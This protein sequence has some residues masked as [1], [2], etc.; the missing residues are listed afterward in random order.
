MESVPSRAKINGPTVAFSVALLFTA[1][2]LIWL[3]WTTLGTN[4]F[5]GEIENRHMRLQE[6]RGSIIHLDEVL[7]MSARMAATT[8]EP[9][10]EARYRAHESI[11]TDAINEALSLTPNSEAES[12]VKKTDAANLALIEMENKAFELVRQNRL[13]DAK[14]ILFSADYAGQKATYAAGMEN[15]YDELDAYIESAIE[16]KQA[17]GVAY[18]WIIVAALPIIAICWFIAVRAMMRWQIQLARSNA[19]LEKQSKE[20]ESINSS[21]DR[22]VAERTA[23][24]DNARQEALRLKDVAEGSNRAK[25]EFLA[26]MSHEIRTPMNGIIGMTELALGTDLTGEQREYLE[27]VKISGDSL[28]GVI[29]DILDFSKIEARRLDLDLIE[30][31]LH[32]ALEETVRLLAPRAHQKGLE[33]AY[34]LSPGVPPVIISDP[35]RIRQVIVNLVGNSVKFTESGE[36]VVRIEKEFQE[37]KRAT[38]RFSVMDTGIGVP[39]DKQ[40]KIFEAFTQADS[41]TTRRFGGTGLGLAIASQLVGLMGGRI[42]VESQAGEGSKFHFTLPVEVASHVSRRAVPK[43]LSDLKDMPVLVVDDNATNRRIMEEILVQWGM[44]PLVVDGGKTALEAMD[45]ATA[46]GKPYSLILIDYQMP[47]MDGFEL[48]NR[49]KSNPALAAS[50]IMMLSSVGQRGDAI[51]CRELGVAS[52]LTKPIRQSVLLDALLVLLANPSVPAEPAP[53]VTKHSLREASKSL[54]VL[55]AEDNPVNQML[56]VKMLQKRG[57]TIEVAPDGRAAVEAW[58]RGEFDAILMDVQMPIMD[59]LEATGEIRRREKEKGTH[60]PIIAMTAHAMRGDRERCLDAGMDAY[61]PKPIHANDLFET[62]E[63]LMPTATTAVR[64]PKVRTR[65]SS[66]DAVDFSA[67]LGRVDG[68]RELLSEVVELFRADAPRL[69]ENVKSAIE[70]KDAKALAFAA[71]ALKGALSAISAHRASQAALVLEVMGRENDWTSSPTAALAKLESELS[72]AV[73][74]IELHFEAKV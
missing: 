33:L 56:A 68:D 69:V 52:Y 26:N 12:V 65:T 47:G 32:Y 45:R 39:E 28:L 34:H 59:G 8:G 36:I 10:W 51:R 25:S 2:L 1:T 14:T 63:E 62:L 22:K 4:H 30:F 43:E 35:G 73:E 61:L 66:G 7:T 41:S 67:L 40:A 42:W 3:T 38:L 29:N 18:L 58:E 16:A 31:D 54:R 64:Q 13:V 55:L 21:L 20:L 11:L 57:H 6:L 5:L 71:H 9:Q 48:A 50:T 27:M 24:L 49:I 53:L 70:A 60:T 23:E 74:A 37:G 72:E 19:N 17:Q 46:M 44:K 15:L